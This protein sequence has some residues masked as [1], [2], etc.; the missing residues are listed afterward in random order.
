MHASDG[1]LSVAQALWMGGKKT[2]KKNE[3]D[4]WGGAILCNNCSLK[5]VTLESTQVFYDEEVKSGVK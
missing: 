3:Q 5:K 1:N 2:T 4:K